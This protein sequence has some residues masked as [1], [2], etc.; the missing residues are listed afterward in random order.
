VNAYLFMVREFAN[1]DQRFE[2][3]EALQPRGQSLA[4]TWD[5]DAVWVEF[6]RTMKAE[7][8]RGERGERGR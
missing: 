5:D 2:I 6:E 3:D 7:R 4:D 8:R 1:E